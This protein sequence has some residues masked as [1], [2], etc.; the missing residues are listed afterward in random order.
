MLTLGLLLALHA[1]GSAHEGPP[2]P[3]FVDRA[4]GAYVVSVW[5][6]PDVGTGTFIVVAEPPPGGALPE[7]L[8]VEVCV[9]PTDLRLAEACHAAE[10]ERTRERAQFSGAVPFD[11]QGLWHVRVVLRGPSGEGETAVDVEVTPDGLGRW[12]LLL[13]F[14]PFAAVGFLWLRAAFKGRR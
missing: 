11:A 14:F 5:A 6:D 9:R 12:D 2:Y 10:R 8:K 4:V 1:R 3:L 7:G 13:Y